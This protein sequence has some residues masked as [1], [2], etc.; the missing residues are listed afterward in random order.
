MSATVR[1]RL[2]AV[3]SCHAKAWFVDGRR[4]GGEL[5]FPAMVAVIEHP[6]AG[7]I[8]FDT[9]YG[10]PLL[11]SKSRAARFYRS[12]LP[13]HLA[14]DKRIVR[15][16][17]GLGVRPTEL[18]AI[19]LS[20]FHPDHVGGLC[21]LPAVPLIY[22]R[23]GLD[24][25][26]R[27]RGFAR[28]R[29]VFLPELLPTDFDERA[30]AIEDL[31]AVALDERWHPFTTAHDLLGDG[32]LLAVA[33]PGHALGQHG[34]ICRLAGGRELFLVA[35]A[36]WVHTNV[37]DLA[38]PVWLVRRLLGDGKALVETLRLLHALRRRQPELLVVPS[39][40]KVSQRAFTAS[41]YGE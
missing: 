3:G 30:H 25:L 33:L 38:L 11:E 32:S 40:C 35:D 29:E 10:A 4:G 28:W 16:L 9:G 19:F 21:E 7:T 24:K 8:L 39:H 37:D 13:F 31:P 5:T 12:V 22:S 41:G 23:E 14:D 18:R 27:S 17:E 1:V 36:A 15:Q 2:L 34:L 26:R 20:H 6:G